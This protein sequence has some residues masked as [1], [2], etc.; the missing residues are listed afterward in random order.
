MNFKTAWKAFWSILG[1]QEKADAWLSLQGNAALPS[2]QEQP[3]QQAETPA[4]SG[5]GNGVLH[6]LGILQREDRFVD[7][8]QEDLA[9]Y[10]DEQVGAAARKVHDDCRRTLEKYFSIRP[11]RTEEESTTVKVDAGFDSREIRLTGRPTGEP[12]YSGVLVH[13]GW[14]ADEVNLPQR[15]ASQNPAILCPAEIE[16]NYPQR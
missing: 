1:S 10:S 3:A 5:E 8:L 14:R 2:P 15:N 7:F 12:P 16:I 4:Q 13:R 6:L 9:P 11:V